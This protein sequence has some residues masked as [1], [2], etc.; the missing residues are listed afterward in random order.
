LRRVYHGGTQRDG[1][2][3]MGDGRMGEWANGRMGEW[4][5]GRMGEWANG[6]WAMGDGR[7]AMGEWDLKVALG[8]NVGLGGF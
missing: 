5:N 8:F 2:T 6:R 3:A 7:W 1:E 4:A